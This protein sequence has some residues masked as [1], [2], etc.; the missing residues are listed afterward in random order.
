M[1]RVLIRIRLAML[2]EQSKWLHAWQ[3]LLPTIDATGLYAEM[4]QE[5]VS[6]TAKLV[7]LQKNIARLERALSH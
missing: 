5:Y 3:E 7:D 1:K 6:V 2:R 4:R